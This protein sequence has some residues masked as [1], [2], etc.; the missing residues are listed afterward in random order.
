M[1]VAQE[2]ARIE[3][4]IEQA[5]LDQLHVDHAYYKPKLKGLE[6]RN[7]TLEAYL[8]VLRKRLEAV[9]ALHVHDNEYPGDDPLDYFCGTCSGREGIVLEEMG[10][11]EYPCRTRSA[12][13]G[14]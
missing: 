7:D 6:E 4:R 11:R 9:L 8:D 1:S 10:K 14:T 5:Q 13:E 2:E 3:A 12:A